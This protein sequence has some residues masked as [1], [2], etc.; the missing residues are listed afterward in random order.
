MPEGVGMPKRDIPATLRHT[1]GLAGEFI[2]VVAVLFGSLGVG[3]V[4]FVGM[5]ALQGA[6][7]AVFS[8]VL[9]IAAIHH[10][11]YSRNREAIESS[12]EQKAMRE[13]RGF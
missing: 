7:L 2:F 5:D 4:L 12:H 11:W 13:R 9:I 8:V 3:V 6:G 1:G 10:R